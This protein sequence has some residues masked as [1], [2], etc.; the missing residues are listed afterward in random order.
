MIAMTTNNSISVKPCFLMV[1]FLQYGMLTTN[2]QT[3]EVTP[4]V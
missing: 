4:D 2:D 1:P 3:N